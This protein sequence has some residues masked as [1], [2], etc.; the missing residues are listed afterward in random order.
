MVLKM[1]GTSVD[2]HR[3]LCLEHL[4]CPFWTHFLLCT[5]REMEGWG[6]TPLTSQIPL[7]AQTPQEREREAHRTRRGRG[8]ARRATDLDVIVRVPVRVIDD[9]CVCR[10]QVDT[11]AA[12]TGGEQEAELLGPRG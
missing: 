4:P 9:D 3:L 10:S 2:S 7:G 5:M 8:V 1:M 6:K 11:Q 12:R